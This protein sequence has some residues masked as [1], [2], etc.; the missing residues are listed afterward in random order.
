[1]TEH[2]RKLR[3]DAGMEY[4]ANG[5]FVRA[6]DCFKE[7]AKEEWHD[8]ILLNN[9][10]RDAQYELAML[11]EQ[12][13]CVPKR[14]DE[15]FKYYKMAADQGHIHALLQVG[16]L[17]EYGPGV[18]KDIKQA[19][20]YYKLAAKKGEINGQRN[21]GL[22]YEE[23]AGVARNLKKAAEWYQQAAN[24]GLIGGKW[25][26]GSCYEHGKG[27]DQDINKAIK[28]Y[29]EVA[30][31]K[32]DFTQKAQYALALCYEKGKVS[33]VAN[34]LQLAFHWL[35]KAAD[36]GHTEA[37]FKVA[38]C[39]ENGKGVDK[40]LNESFKYNKILADQGKAGAQ[41]KV[42]I[43]Y[44]EGTGVAENKKMAAEYYLKSANQKNLTAQCYRAWCCEEGLGVAQNFEEAFK[45]YE[46]AV[47]NNQQSKWNWKDFEEGI[48][49]SILEQALARAKYKMGFFY[50]RGLIVAKDTEK[51]IQYL[52]MAV[53][54]GQSD[55][56][57][58]LAACCELGDGMKQDMKRAI[59]LYTLSS[60]QKNALGQYNLG[61]CYENGIGIKKN[62]EMAFKLYK[63][64][65]DKNNKLG[66]HSLGVCYE[67]GVGVA[68]DLFKA[69]E[70]YV[71]AA[72]E[73][74]TE[75]A[76]SMKRLQ[77]RIK[78]SPFANAPAHMISSASS[79]DSVSPSSNQYSPFTSSLSVKSSVSPFAPNVAAL[80]QKS[81]SDN[82][83]ILE[84]RLLSGE[85]NF[86]DL[87]LGEVLGKGAFG[88]VYKGTWKYR[89]GCVVAIKK[90]HV[91]GDINPE[92]KKEIMNE[93]QMMKNLQSPNLVEFY[94]YTTNPYSLVMEYVPQGSL[95]KWLHS[96]IVITWDIK[97]KVANDMVKG[98]ASLHGHGII[99]RDIKGQNVLIDGQNNA[100]FADFGL[101]K[102]K[103]AQT[104]SAD[105][106]KGIVGTFA[107]TAP[108]IFEE[109]PHTMKSDIY[110]LGITL[111][112]LVSGQQPY[113]N[114][115]PP[116]IML[117]VMKGVQDPI[118]EGCHP[119][120]ATI[121]QACRAVDPKARPSAEALVSFFASGQNDF[122]AFCPGWMALRQAASA[123]PN[124]VENIRITTPPQAANLS[125][126]SSFNAS[127]VGNLDSENRGV[128]L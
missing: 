22:C 96:G 13:N 59:E 97:I 42:G 8:K 78:V 99:H 4:K 23:G 70:F 125:N 5:D 95:L 119:K 40:N 79:M 108:E 36:T 10:N 35:K 21:V 25:Q 82:K 61:R 26:L 43:F 52:E 74:H 71:L 80:D 44:D 15:A 76:N 58:E 39:Y 38:K 83:T 48:D 45:W 92:D 67:N 73:G 103:Q 64:S 126:Y 65:A 90:F 123:A 50:K 37:Q 94:G 84:T 117:K 88:T 18:D 110:S 7:A 19:F 81:E 63:A 60:N 14:V 86:S 32:N 105:S 54:E 20:K 69:L 9:G 114:I 53:K 33:E 34:Q 111:W 115:N 46:A 93:I 91:Q 104:N 30:T 66:L 98:L 12:G 55:A 106:S 11:Y 62:V 87:T 29:E 128:R 16:F 89:P 47:N 120:L 113:K 17:Y 72:K 2:E 6:A 56:Q 24:N 28:L 109:K 118:P 107:W 121:I 27:V 31:T 1:M 101:A 85:I 116:S 122:A 124:A 49:R 68:I 57:N 51:A 41:L 127:L 100:K 75:A 102:V 112:E 77:S 3:Y